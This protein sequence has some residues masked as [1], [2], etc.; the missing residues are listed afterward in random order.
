MDVKTLE[1]CEYKMASGA[2]QVFPNGW[3]GSVSDELGQEWIEA[4]QAEAVEMISDDDDFNAKQA[5]VL[6]AAADQMIAAQE[7][8]EVDFNSLKVDDLKTIAKDAGIDGFKDM[9]KAELVAVLEKALAEELAVEGNDGDGDGND[10][11]GDALK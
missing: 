8:G 9:K 6:R 5:A 3:V 7:D 11:N 1:R 10:A 2:K 4:G